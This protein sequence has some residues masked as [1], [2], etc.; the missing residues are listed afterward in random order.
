MSPKQLEKCAS[1]KHLVVIKGLYC[2]CDYCVNFSSYENIWGG[3]QEQ[4]YH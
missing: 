1:C 2:D 4:K 3:Y